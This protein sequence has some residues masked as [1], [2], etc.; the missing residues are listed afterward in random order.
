MKYIDSHAHY[1]SRRF[2][3]DRDEV[4]KKLFN[5]VDITISK[6]VVDDQLFLLDY[7]FRNFKENDWLEE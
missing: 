1:L 4:L 5:Y 6:R 7:K 2:M 3:S